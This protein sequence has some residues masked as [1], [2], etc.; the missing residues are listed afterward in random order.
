MLTIWYRERGFL[1][2]FLHEVFVRV[3][4]YR[5]LFTIIGDTILI[6]K[7]GPRDDAYK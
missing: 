2:E 4:K 6:A 1:I 7:I 5:V 3:G